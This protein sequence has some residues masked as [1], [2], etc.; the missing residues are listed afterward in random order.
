MDSSQVAG[1][2]LRSEA[3]LQEVNEEIYKHSLELAVVNKTLSLLRLAGS[4][5]LKYTYCLLHCGLRRLWRR[6]NW[7]KLRK[8][9]EIGKSQD[10]RPPNSHS[11]C[12]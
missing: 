7:G 2:P 11:Q 3:D 6:D 9:V 1:V 4:A 10:C 5:H 8:D 12:D